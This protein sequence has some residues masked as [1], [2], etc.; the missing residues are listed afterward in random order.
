[1]IPLW[2]IATLGAASFQV[3]RFM[4]QK[5]LKTAGFSSAGAT[6]ARY[7]ISPPLVALGVL[8]YASASAQDLP[9]INARFLGF[10]FV[11]GLG[12]I[13]ATVCVVALFGRRNFAVGVTLKKTEVM[14]A[15]LFGVVIL[16]EGV[17]FWPA[18][19]IG[20]GFAAVLLLSK[21]GAQVRATG[22]RGV[23]SPSAILG[24]LSGT[25]FGI[26]AVSFRGATLAL[27]GGDVFLRAATTLAVVTLI[28]ACLMVIYLRLREPG[29]IRRVVG[30]RRF[31]VALGLLSIGG[32]MCWFTAFALQNAAYV[33]ALGQVE[34]VF[35]LIASVMVFGER[36]SARELSGM[37]LLCG[38]VVLL[39]LTT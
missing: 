38:S 32:S 1:M 10:A 28:Q 19:A 4:L 2:I 7:V 22:W 33:N 37:G 12:Q 18:V 36:P 16:D 17:A 29:E 15:A 27:E 31:V 14:L 8:A 39:V 35:S 30:A 6:F 26:C 11:G 20:I 25:F 5:Q 9:G 3:F 13:L 23:I 24:L 34:L 21:D